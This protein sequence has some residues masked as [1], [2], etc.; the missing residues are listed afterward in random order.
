M[1]RSHAIRSAQLENLETRRL[2]NVDVDPIWI[3]SV[4]VEEDSGSD[5]HG[6]SFYITFRGG[7]AGTRLNQLILRTDQGTPGF[8]VADNL[9]DTQGTGRGA[10][11]SFPFQIESLDAISPSARVRAEVSD[12]GM[13]LILHFENFFAGDKLHFSID[14]DEVQHLYSIT[15]IGEFNEGLD[16]ITSGAEFEGSRMVASFEAPRFE[17]ATVEG[18][19]ANRYDP[20]LAPSGLDLPQDN[21]GGLRDRSAGVAASVVQ[22]P[23]PISLA[24]VVYVDNNISFTQD[25]NEPGIAG[26]GLELLRWEGNRYVTTGHRTTTDAQGRYAFGLALGLQPGR[27]QIRETQPQGY[28][29]V[30]AIP[31]LLDGS[32]LLGENIEGDP[33]VLTEIAILQGDSHGTE[34]NFAEAQPSRIS[35]YVYRDNNNDGVRTSQEGGVED[36]T[37]RIVSVFTVTGETITRTTRTA[38][39]GSYSFLS[40][41]PG[42]YTITEV[43][44]IGL[45]DGKDT[46]GRVRG[47]PRGDVINNDELS[48]I[49]LDGNETGEEYNFGE[50]EPSSLSG[51]VCVAMPGYTCFSEDPAGKQPV[52]GVRI[53]LVNKDGVVVGTTFTGQDGTYRFEGLVPGV[54][55]ILETQPTY[56][57]DGGSRA[58]TIEGATRGTAINGTR[59]VAINLDGGENGT[60]YDFCE[61]LPASISGYVFQ[62]GDE[63]ITPDGLP[64]AN[65]RGIRDGVR[66]PDDR[67]LAGV[68]LELRRVDG[69]QASA[70]D[71]LPGTVSGDVIRVQTNA[72]GYYEFIGL[73][74]GKYHVYQV[75]QPG[76]LFDGLD[77]AGS[78]GG[79]ADN[80]Y[81][82][83]V[84]P[85]VEALMDSLR[86][87]ASTDPNH[88]AILLIQALAGVMSQNNNFSE[89]SVLPEIKSPPPDPPDPPK[90]PVTPPSTP[91]PP[92]E[93]PA[94]VPTRLPEPGSVPGPMTPLVIMALPPGRGLETSLA[95]YAVEYAWHL[96]IIDAGE[97]RGFHGEKHV[98]RQTIAS[99]SKV[100]NVT[101]W[102]IDTM[103]RGRWYIV[104]KNM[105]AMQKNAF[106]VRGAK[107]LAGDFN[108]DGR[109]EL[110]LFKDGEWL[111]DMNSNGEWDRGDM[112]IRLGDRGDLPVV[113]DWDG[114]GK[115]DIGIYGTEWPED[116]DRIAREPGLPDPDNRTWSRP[117]NIPE[118]SRADADRK[119][120]GIRDYVR[121]MQRSAQ[122]EG[123]ADPIDHVFR[124][125][126]DGYQ[127]VAGDFNGSGVSKV[128]V[129]RDGRWKLDMD[130]DGRFEVDRDVEFVFG[131]A[132]DI[133]IVGDFNGDGLDEIAVVR[134]NQVMIDSNGNGRLDATDRVFQI[135]GD[136]DGVVVGDF[137]GDGIDEAAFYTLGRDS[138]DGIRQAKAG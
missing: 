32:P 55:T 87:S 71:A 48:L 14:V 103:N 101:H 6:D 136:G 117:K 126:G 94:V 12:G 68:T 64:P 83:V 122:G 74:P 40:L 116:A 35:G 114:D 96:S 5:A 84:D 19:F 106:S 90:P 120:D 57:F 85:V 130:G 28:I 56:L 42:V 135:E 23:K 93:R 52:P 72:D 125:G 61:V 53:D 107:Q 59:I 102:T 75:Q 25:P 67:P 81:D 8:T 47:E 15:D 13:E 104:S 86:Q 92:I 7:A 66:T 82:P 76:G 109:D 129:F 60:K 54:Y 100:L 18:V 127:P 133:A 62:D 91:A 3:G 95:G 58:G 39:D 79:T 4:Y 37:I 128:G 115:D 73:K 10:D 118:P 121:L 123:R 44:P 137:D 134:G 110:A 16:P 70:S 65:L 11:H 113:G 108:G 29:S 51:S 41:P 1:T 17:D 45:I 88:D 21:A 24:G 124:F 69:S 138:E 80:P 38:A 119:A 111:L 112:W 78:T 43:Q 30:G 131:Q 77:T 22:E 27:Y 49:G 63:L 33:D 20:M 9:F 50:I 31:G 105:S 26:V 98:D 36:V 97:P 89:V 99:A 132:G 46:I 34:L 2:F